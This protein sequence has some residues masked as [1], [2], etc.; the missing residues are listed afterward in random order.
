V[1]TDCAVQ[2][3]HLVVALPPEAFQQPREPPHRKRHDVGEREPEAAAA[4]LAVEEREDAL[5]QVV[6]YEQREEGA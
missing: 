6:A 1:L 3:P 5:P 4:V 2:A